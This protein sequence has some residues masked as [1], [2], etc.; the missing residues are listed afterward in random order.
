MFRSN[1][2]FARTGTFEAHA[3]IRFASDIYI[4]I[5][6]GIPTYK[7]M[8]QTGIVYIY[9]HLPLNASQRL[10]E[11][12]RKA[13]LSHD[14][15]RIDW[16]FFSSCVYAALLFRGSMNKINNSRIYAEGCNE[17]INKNVKWIQVYIQYLPILIIVI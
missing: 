17:N 9:I 13:F 15:V 11:S 8:P 5:G 14:V 2:T 7:G 4:Y 6:I 12:V 1:S 10:S 16:P 3:H